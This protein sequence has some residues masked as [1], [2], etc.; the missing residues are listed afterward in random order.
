MSHGWG[1]QVRSY[2]LDAGTRAAAPPPMVKDLR[3]GRETLD[4]RSVLDGNLDAF[5]EDGVRR[6]AERRKW[7][8][9]VAEYEMAAIPD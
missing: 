1:Y 5:L 4:V 6:S 7:G 3:S 8:A 2:V 9:P